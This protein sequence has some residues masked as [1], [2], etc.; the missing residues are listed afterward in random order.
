M[1]RLSPSLENS[2]PRS[3]E[4]TLNGVGGG[5]CSGGDSER[6][7]CVGLGDACGVGGDC[8]A[9]GG[10]PVEGVGGCVFETAGI[11]V[12]EPDTAA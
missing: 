6:G 4:L 7:L 8:G 1:P 5:V 2:S 12:P 11:P 10:P 9:V 3:T